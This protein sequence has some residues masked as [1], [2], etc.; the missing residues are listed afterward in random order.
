MITKFGHKYKQAHGWIGNKV[1]D[2]RRQGS[3]IVNNPVVQAVGAVTLAVAG[4]VAKK[5]V[6]NVKESRNERNR[7]ERIMAQHRD[8]EHKRQ[9][10]RIDP[11]GAA[12]KRLDAFVESKPFESA[13]NFD[14]PF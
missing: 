3:K 11:G 8:T 4:A 2:V 5:K 10:E 9:M 12:K 7:G 1:K 14:E 13:F 6:D